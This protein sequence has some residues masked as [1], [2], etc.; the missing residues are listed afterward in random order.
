MVKHAGVSNGRDKPV[1]LSVAVEVADCRT[2]AV[3]LRT[4]AGRA[5]SVAEGAVAVVPKQPTR[6]EVA[7]DDQIGMSV[8][9][10]IGKPRREGKHIL[11]IGGQ[12]RMRRRTP[13]QGHSRGNRRVVEEARLRGAAITQQ[14]RRRTAGSWPKG[15]PS[16][17]VE[18]DEAV[19][20]VVTKG[21]PETATLKFS[22]H[23]GPTGHC[24]FAE[25]ARPVVD[26]QVIPLRYVGGHVQVEI[27][28][29][30]D[31]GRGGP[32][33]EKAG[34]ESG[35]RGNIGKCA[36]ALVE[37]K[38]IALSMPGDEQVNPTVAIEITRHRAA[39]HGVGAARGV[40]ISDAAEGRD[41]RENGG[42]HIMCRPGAGPR[43]DRDHRHGRNP[44]AHGGFPQ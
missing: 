23:I 16:R 20:I 2:H 11:W 36:V 43:S 13:F 35:R 39:G 25:L 14:L 21:R 7:G 32:A 44:V 5:G 10:E 31:V 19:A 33:G 17:G 4:D 1:E 42:R 26:V 24:L 27:A 34:V 38:N 8:S 37:V 9:V 30:V 12:I 29:V 18:I 6:A 15:I 40:L 3:S 41:I 22:R 28:V